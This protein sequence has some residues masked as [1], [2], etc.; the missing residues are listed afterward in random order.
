MGDIFFDLGNFCHHHRFS[1]ELVQ[2]LL[3]EYFGEVT[4]KVF[5]HLKLMWPMSTI[6]EAMWGT[7]QTGI[8]TL[9]EDFQGYADLWFARHAGSHDRSPLA[10]VAKGRSE[11]MTNLPS[12]AASRHHRRRRRRHIR[13]LPPHPDG[14]EGR[15]PARA[16]GTHLRLDLA[17]GWPGGPAAFR[18][19]P[20]AHDEVQHRPV[21][22]AQ[23]RNRT[24]HGLARG[25]RLALG[26]DPAADGRA[27]TA[28]GI[29]PLVW[30]AAGNDQHGPGQEDV[31]AD[32]RRG[33][34]G[35]GV[36]PDGRQHRSDGADHGTRS[37]RQEPRR[38]H[39]PRHR[40]HRHYHQ[41][42]PGG[43]GHHQSGADQDRDRGQL[44]RP[45]GRRHLQDGR[46]HA[47]DRALCPPVP[48][49]QARRRSGPQRAD[50]ARPGPPGL[51]AR[52][53]RRLH[54]RGLRKQPARAA[55]ERHRRGVQVQAVPAGLGALYAR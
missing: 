8:S 32:E 30:H 54:H 46:H 49:H 13:R 51:L 50:D 7:T 29:R 15:R 53:S 3:Q 26:I 1:D 6:H 31:P 17:F 45:V 52:G 27:Q 18:F 43:R 33:R 9:D 12:Q 35:G 10:S 16:R 38:P 24:G 21:P 11:E 20:D 42:R 19:Q 22:A 34:A 14:V 47:A 36:D 48:D 2:V 55:D 4:P 5:A 25:W 39:L 40:G 37:G 41:E 44:R 23:G 28:G